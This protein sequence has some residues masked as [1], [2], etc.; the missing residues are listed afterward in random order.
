MNKLKT[1]TVALLIAVLP[2]A[3]AAF[4]SEWEHGDYDHGYRHDRPEQRWHHYQY[5]HYD[6]RDHHDYDDRYGYDHHD[7]GYRA[8]IILTLPAFPVIVVNQR[9]HEAPIERYHH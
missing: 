2:V 8:G 3:P 6:H 5:R 7:L 4:A 9:L 1:V